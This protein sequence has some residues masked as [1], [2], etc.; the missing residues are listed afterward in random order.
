MNQRKKKKKWPW[1]VGTLAAVVVAVYLLLPKGGSF[2]G[3]S[4]TSTATAE[5][6]DL[7]IT[8]IG[9]GNLKYDDAIE[10]Q[11]PS[12][13]VIDK[14]LVESGDTVSNGD[15]LAMVDPL[16][17]QTQIASVRSQIS[18]VEKEIDSMKT[19]TETEVIKTNL[20]G[21]I[22]K[23]Y[24]EEGD[25]A[26][27]VY[28]DSGALILLSI[29][30]KMA[31]DFESTT[32]LSIG[33]TV[34][35]VLENGKLKEGTVERVG[36]GGYTVTLTDNGTGLDEKVTIESEDGDTLGFGILYVNQPIKIIASYGDIKTI[37][38]SENDKVGAGKAL[39]TL[40]NLPT[41]IDYEQ[42]I[43]E[44][45][46]LM[47]QL[48]TLLVLT[49]T[50]TII[51]EF[52]GVVVSAGIKD[53]ETI[54]GTETSSSIET[55]SDSASTSAASSAAVYP[56]ASAS[57]SAPSS[58]QTQTSSGAAS[59]SLQTV[60]TITP[61]DNMVLSVNVDEL[62][63]LSINEGMEVQIA[64]DAIANETFHGEIIKIADSTTASGGVAKYLVEVLVKKDTSMRAGMSATATILVENRENIL[65]IPVVAL[66]ETNGHVYVYTQRD[67]KTGELSD[68]VDVVTGISDGDK[69]EI[70]DGLS[71][72]DTVYYRITESETQSFTGMG[73][74]GERFGGNGGL[75]SDTGGAP[76]Q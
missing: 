44:R 14:V 56:G 75:N 11:A 50:N 15:V 55:D 70:T 23:I 17:L 61:N 18:S 32:E 64:I 3:L 48:D 38:V 51:S 37:H 65:L 76:R 52:S 66:Q 63:I 29:D 73:G 68:I 19:D 60:F 53:G 39:I 72:G 57:A 8:V 27:D 12:G 59:V 25:A 7:A 2:L 45:N 33:D 49:K 62:D 16:S 30:E 71:N 5:N 69:V 36:I 21:R 9:T 31:V 41:S 22:K 34:N 67:S 4:M 40:E 10:V 26:L 13:I 54:G 46:T 43:D 35:V 58:S 28:F 1:V 42:L 20:A 47:K 24:A 6:G 74:I